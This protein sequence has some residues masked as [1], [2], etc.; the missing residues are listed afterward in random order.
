M[1]ASE[2]GA[3]A[4]D[5]PAAIRDH[6][7]H[8]AL[9]CD[10]LGSPFTASL[11]RALAEVL[12]GSTEIG[13]R[14]LSWAG[15]MREDALSL[16]LC[17][18]LHALVLSGADPVL[19]AAYPPNAVASQADLAHVL[20]DAISRNA[21]AL[22]IALDSAPQTNEI[23]RSAMLLPGFLAIAR[24]T[25]LTMEVCE[26]GS[27]AGLNLLFDS[28]AYDFAGASWGL[29]DSP[30]RLT[31]EVRGAAIPLG[32]RLEIASRVGND[33]RPIDVRDPVQRL[34]LRSYIWADQT[35]R[36]ARLDAA[37]ALAERNPYRL[38]RAEAADFVEREL[39]NRRAHAVWVLVHSIMW[40]YMPQASKDAITTVLQRAGGAATVD[41]PIAWLRMEP[42]DTRN[43]YATLSLTVWPG[44]ETRHLA[45]CDYHGRWI[46]WIA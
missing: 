2:T 14:V 34:R 44:G 33:I 42:L 12:D 27:S 21:T 20:P 19:A 1:T 31:P 7:R 5:G 8:Q 39:R 18:G 6:F 38:E 41:A 11:C 45:R 15:R 9:A 17:G 10:T 36:L 26:I 22:D 25:G 4:E 3:A 37:I 29:D 28:F 35:L 30:V 46:E 32:G 43:P 40:Q 24:E 16:R 13:R 23:A